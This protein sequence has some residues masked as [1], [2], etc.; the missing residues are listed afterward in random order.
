VNT[1]TVTSLQSGANSAMAVVNV[2]QDAMLTV[3]KKASVGQV[4]RAGQVIT[5]TVEAENTGTINLDNF[6]VSDPLLNNALTCSPVST[7]SQ[8]GVGRRTTCTG[9]YTVRQ[10]DMNRGANIVNEATVLTTQAGPVGAMDVTKVLQIPSFTVNKTASPSSV[11]RA[12]QARQTSFFYFFALKKKKKTKQNNRSLH[13]RCKSGN[14]SLI[15]IAFSHSDLLFFF[16]KKK[17]ILETLILRT[18]K[19]PIE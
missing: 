9:S 14:G 1:A 16:T 2:A 5:Y 13:F 8:L 11:S 19:S 7:G 3:T 6:Q 12:G 17:G 18:C 15:F 4:D 10:V